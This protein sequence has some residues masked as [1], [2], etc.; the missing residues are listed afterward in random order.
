[1]ALS[2]IDFVRRLRL[3][4]EAGCRR[5]APRPTSARP[6]S[7]R[8]SRDE[9]IEGHRLCCFA[10]R[11]L[12]LR[13]GALLFPQPSRSGGGLRNSDSVACHRISASLSRAQSSGNHKASRYVVYEVQNIWALRCARKSN[14]DLHGV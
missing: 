12:R 9:R 1:M 3:G 14:L 2:D 10:G 7:V 11:F 4:R 13:A 5:Q 8:Y 6:T